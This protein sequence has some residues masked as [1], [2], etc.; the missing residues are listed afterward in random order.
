MST[1]IL[2]KIIIALLFV[3]V[4]LVWHVGDLRIERKTLRNEIA[5]W[6][7]SYLKLFNSKR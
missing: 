6:R 1:A 4:G 5:L 7:Q 3:I 2:L